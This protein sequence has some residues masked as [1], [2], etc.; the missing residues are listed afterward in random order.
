MERTVIRYSFEF[1]KY[2]EKKSKFWE[3]SICCIANPVHVNYRSFMIL[4]TADKFLNMKVLRWGICTAGKISQD[5]SN[6]ICDLKNH[7]IQAIAS[8]SLEKAQELAG[9]VGVE[10]T[11][12]S[13]ESLAADPNIGSYNATATPGIKSMHGIG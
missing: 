6:A 9:K 3:K 12:A 4:M 13:Y 1:Q 10:T 11:Y 2:E 8:R 5:F 7:K